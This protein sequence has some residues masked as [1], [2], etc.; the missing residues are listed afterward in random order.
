MEEMLEV[1]R[2]SGGICKVFIK[3]CSSGSHT[4]LLDSFAITQDAVVTGTRTYSAH[5]DQ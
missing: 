2:K 4:V 1:E 3:A 5:F